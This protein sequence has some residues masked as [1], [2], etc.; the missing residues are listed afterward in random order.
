MLLYT[1]TTTVVILLLA[2]V[3]AAPAAADDDN[4][5]AAAVA[6]DSEIMDGFADVAGALDD[7]RDGRLDDGAVAFTFDGVLDD[8]QQRGER[9]GRIVADGTIDQS[10]DD[11]SAQ[12]EMLPKEYDILA[13]F[14]EGVR[15]TSALYNSDHV[16]RDVGVEGVRE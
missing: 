10:A 2:A 12:H 5:V 4:V 6:G 1:T 16:G 14:A 7:S 3:A 11:A 8:G 13:A 9:D 15:D